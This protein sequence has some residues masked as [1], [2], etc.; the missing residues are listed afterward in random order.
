MAKDRFKDYREEL[1]FQKA[2]WRRKAGLRKLYH[3]WYARIVDAL[4]EH[5]PTVEIGSGC[6]NFKEFYPDVVATDAMDVGPH[7]DRIVDARDLPFGE[8][9]VGN[10]VLIDVLHHLPRPLRFLRSAGRCLKRG[11]R[12]VLFEPACTPF[13][14]LLWATCH[15]EPVDLSQ[16]LLA[17]DELDEPPNEGFQF[18]NMAIATILFCRRLDETMSRLPGLRLARLRFSD[19]LVHPATGG[20]SYHSFVP[21]FAVG[22]LH[23]VEDVLTRPLARHL[24]GLRM[25]AVLEKSDAEV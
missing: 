25:L 22:C 10:F 1:E 9:E 2:T 18:T 8:G 13:A 4:S 19:F 16:D 6:G 11:G 15:H 23:A 12:I 20:F 17:E 7:I 21:G 24:T 5:R 14:R 3:R